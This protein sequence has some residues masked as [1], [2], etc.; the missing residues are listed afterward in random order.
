MIQINFTKIIIFYNKCHFQHITLPA[1]KQVYEGVESILISMSKLIISNPKYATLNITTNS[2]M[3]TELYFSTVS[4]TN[5]ITEANL[6][7]KKYELLDN[8]GPSA[9]F[10]TTPSTHSYKVINEYAICTPKQLYKKYPFIKDLVKTLR[11][12]KRTLYAFIIEISN[13]E[14]SV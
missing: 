3:S 8:T 11:L 5:A 9:I 14:P 2:Q 1:Y 6:F 10:K 12:D 7:F 4:K 13:V